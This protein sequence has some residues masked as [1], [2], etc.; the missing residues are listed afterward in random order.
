MQYIKESN[1]F[2]FTIIGPETDIHDRLHY[3]SLFAMLQEAACLDVDHHGFGA[4]K[5]DEL[6]ACWLLLRMKVKMESI[7][8]WKDTIYIKTW[9]CGFN[10]VFFNREFD[11]F[12]ADMNKIGFASSVWIIAHQGDHR[13]VRPQ[14]IEGMEIYEANGQEGREVKK[15]RAFTPDPEID[16]PILSK[17]A[18][19]SEIDRNSHVN[20]TRYIAWSAD[21]FYAEEEDSRDI[22][23]L[24]VNYSSEVRRGEEIQIYRTVDAENVQINGYERETGRHVFS[25]EIR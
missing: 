12:D 7:P 8:K 5:M 20:N 14:T 6:E 16:R 22:S 21:A 1:L 3:H 24:T 18:D 9:S 25:T 4:D 11:I 19:Y 2:Q 23:E 13:P 15:L 17:F 10:R